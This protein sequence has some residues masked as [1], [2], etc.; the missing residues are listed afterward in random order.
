M[1]SKYLNVYNLIFQ[2]KVNIYSH[3]VLFS[4]L[5][6]SIITLIW[7]QLGFS[8][9]IFYKTTSVL[10]LFCY[11]NR[12]AKLWD[13]LSSIKNRTTMLFFE[14]NKNFCLCYVNGSTW[15]NR[16]HYSMINSKFWYQNEGNPQGN[17]RFMAQP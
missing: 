13:C 5:H 6:K 10:C 7:D 4:A 11:K 3:F 16:E 9:V 15:A 2:R 14:L 8:H 1:I 12:F 17:E